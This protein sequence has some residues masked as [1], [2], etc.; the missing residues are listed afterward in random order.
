MAISIISWNCHGYRAHLD[1]LKTL[2][3]SVHPICV[4]LQETML[5]PLIQTKLKH[6]NIIRKDNIHD[7]RPIGGVALLYSQSFPSKI[8]PLDTLQAT[9]IQ[10]NI[11]THFTLCSLYLPPKQIIRPSELDDLVD[12]LPAPLIIF[13][14]WNGHNVLWGSAD[15]NS[16]GRHIYISHLE[17]FKLWTWLYVLPS[18]LPKWTFNVANDLYNSDH[19]PIILT[20]YSNDITLPVRP[21]HFIYDK[22]NWQLYAQ[23]AEFSEHMV[24]TAGIDEVVDHI[25]HCILEAA[26]K[27]IPMT[28]GKLPKQ[29]KPWWNQE[30]STAH[31]DQKRAWDRFRRY[32]TSENL[33]R[34]KHLKAVARRIRRQ[35]QR[36]SWQKYVGGIQ[37]QISSKKLWQRLT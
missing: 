27:S 5:Y 21:S 15:T 14:D 8:V 26:A 20:F 7:A 24:Q 13:G 9:A 34:F 4:G 1:D 3:N 18:L 11:R 6:Y 23:L 32:P 29:N 35:S 17:H 36:A 25:T 30:C 19:F 37:G 12:L 10:I 16:R 22:A 33:L 31:K 2:I 28:V